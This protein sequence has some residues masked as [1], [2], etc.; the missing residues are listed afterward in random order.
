M[1]ETENVSR[2]TDEIEDQ[3]PA[4]Q[5]PPDRETEESDENDVSR[6]TSEPEEPAEQIGR[7]SCRERV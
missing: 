3:Q 6:E 2:E 7:A 4:D 5:D 1:P